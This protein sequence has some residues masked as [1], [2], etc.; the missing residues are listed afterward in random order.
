MYL[1]NSY[2]I[3]LSFKNGL[4]YKYISDEL[5]FELTPKKAFECYG[6]SKY[7]DR[8]YEDYRQYN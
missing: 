4:Q 8:C 3:I 5:I 1:K 6:T 2:F 7:N